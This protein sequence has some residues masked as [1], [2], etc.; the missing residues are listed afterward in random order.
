MGCRIFTIRGDF[1]HFTLH[2]GSLINWILATAI[3]ISIKRN[4]RK[5][6][7][8]LSA[9]LC[10][11]IHITG[12]DILQRRSH[13]VPLIRLQLLFYP[14]LVIYQIALVAKLALRL[15]VNLMTGIA[16]ELFALQ[17]TICIQSLIS[18]CL[19]PERHDVVLDILRSLITLAIG[20][21]GSDAIGATVN[22]ITEVREWQTLQVINSNLGKLHW[23]IA[24]L[25][26]NV[27]F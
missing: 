22:D 1:L 21:L 16:I 23:H 11:H 2:P 7:G 17:I 18:I 15:E 26:R 19:I 24:V 20:Q 4:I 5:R 6:L 8:F 9:I 14:S 12:V 10:R 27:L 13:G 25:R 3:R